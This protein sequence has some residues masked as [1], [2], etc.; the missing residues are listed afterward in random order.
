VGLCCD[1]KDALLSRSVA[2]ERLPATG[3]E[4]T[5]PLEQFDVIAG[6]HEVRNRKELVRG[7]HVEDLRFKPSSPSYLT[8][9]DA[10]SF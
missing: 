2:D 5:Q 8:H 1:L 10:G 4:T 7:R 3:S 9:L 6:R